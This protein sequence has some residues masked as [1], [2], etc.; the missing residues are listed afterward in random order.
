[1]E[2]VIAS[3]KTAEQPLEVQ[4]VAPEIAASPCSSQCRV[5][6]L[7]LYSSLSWSDC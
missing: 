3:R 5:T 2:Q 1:M 4:N 6:Y 7:N